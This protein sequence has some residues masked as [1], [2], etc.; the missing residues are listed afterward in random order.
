MVLLPAAA[1]LTSLLFL[2][3]ETDD[4]EGDLALLLGLVLLVMVI[5]VVLVVVLV[6]ASD[7]TSCLV[8]GVNTA[9]NLGGSL[10]LEVIRIGL[11][12][13]CSLDLVGLFVSMTRRFVLGLGVTRLSTTLLLASKMA[14]ALK[15][16]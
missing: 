16:K 10:S 15:S 4:G 12:R 8:G 9:V 11:I 1:E 14:L 13:P 7:F 2:V 6:V 3:T 5:V